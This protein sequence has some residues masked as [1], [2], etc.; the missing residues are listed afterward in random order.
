MTNYL[1]ATRMLDYEQETIRELIRRRGWD[2]MDNYHKILSIYNYVRDEIRFG[3]NSDDTIPASKVLSDGYGQC[4]TKTTLLMALLRAAGI[5]CRAHGFIIDKGLQRGAM[6][7]WVYKLSPAD[8]LHSW[9]EVYYGGVWYDM[10]GIILDKPYLEKL[11]KSFADCDGSFCGYGVSTDDLKNPPVDWNAN[12]TYIQKNDIKRD[13]GVYDSPDDLFAR[14][15]QQ[16]SR[17]KKLFYRHIARH[18]MNRCV[19]RIRTS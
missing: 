11:Q 9:A 5:P 3:Y 16:L 15:A 10:E 19:N 4:N 2:D 1:Q 17:T 6:P 18:A 13:L 8:L 12:S 7:E 14:H